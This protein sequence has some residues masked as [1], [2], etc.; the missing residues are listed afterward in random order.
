MPAFAVMM[1]GWSIGYFK[2][3]LFPMPS[4]VGR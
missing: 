4:T 1:T 2:E 3:M